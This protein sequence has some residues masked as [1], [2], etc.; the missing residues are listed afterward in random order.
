MEKAW[1]NTCIR[2]GDGISWTKIAQKSNSEHMP[3]PIN[4]HT[5]TGM[6]LHTHANTIHSC[7]QTNNQRTSMRKKLGVCGEH[8]DSRKEAGKG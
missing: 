2:N 1:G 3:P 8:R 7:I 4:T 6:H 5:F